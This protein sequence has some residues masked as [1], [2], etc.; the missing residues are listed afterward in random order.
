MKIPSFNELKKNLKK[1]QI[2]FYESDHLIKFKTFGS[3]FAIVNDKEFINKN[4]QN[5][6]EFFFIE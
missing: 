3:V 1:I 2:N 5:S 6:I 4:Y